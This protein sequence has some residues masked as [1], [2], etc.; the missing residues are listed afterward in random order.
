MRSGSYSVRNLSSLAS[1]TDP[2]DDGVGLM[3]VPHAL[4]ERERRR[5]RVQQAEG[6]ERPYPAAHR[7]VGDPEE[8]PGHRDGE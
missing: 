8:N 1:S 7:K 6:K 5:D 4:G 2:V 3:A